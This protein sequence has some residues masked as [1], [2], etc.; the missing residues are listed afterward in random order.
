MMFRR[1]ISLFVGRSEDTLEDE[2]DV[3]VEG[4]L[5]KGWLGVEN[6]VEYWVKYWVEEEKGEGEEVYVASLK[7]PELICAR[8]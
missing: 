6:W 7:A 2:L 3:I 1:T 4:V 8:S 5:A